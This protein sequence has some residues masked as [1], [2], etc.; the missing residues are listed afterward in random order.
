MTHTE[1]KYNKQQVDLDSDFLAA[2]S[3]S[4]QTCSLDKIHVYNNGNGAN[5]T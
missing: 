4:L 1:N 2:L 3:L 5:I